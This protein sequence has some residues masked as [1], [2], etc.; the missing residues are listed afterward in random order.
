MCLCLALP[1]GLVP[2]FTVEAVVDPE[3]GDPPTGGL[4]ECLE[5]NNSFQVNCIIPG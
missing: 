2:P 1:M 5:D 3:V 4:N